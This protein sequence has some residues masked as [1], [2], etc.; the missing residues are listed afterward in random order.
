MSLRCGYYGLSPLERDTYRLRANTS[1]TRDTLDHWRRRASRKDPD[2]A[3]MSARYTVEQNRIATARVQGEISRFAMDVLGESRALEF[4]YGTGRMTQ[5]LA[6]YAN[7]VV[8]VDFCPEMTARA[9]ARLSGVD[10]VALHTGRLYEMGFLPRAFGVGFIFTIL[11]HI[12][13]DAELKG[14]VNSLK[15]S[16]SR[17]LIGEDVGGGYDRERSVWT[18]LRPVRDYVELFYPCRLT[19]FHETHQANDPIALMLFEPK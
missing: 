15:S 1:G 8:G 5:F 12:L 17:I 7:L 11:A 19:R 2:Q 3:V 14:V 16:A 13:D 4:G 9:T 18:R 10:N 6:R